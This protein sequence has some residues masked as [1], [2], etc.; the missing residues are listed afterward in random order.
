MEDE[1]AEYK[2]LSLYLL[3]RDKR[4]QI[5]TLLD[6][7]EVDIEAAYGL[8]AKTE[9]LPVEQKYNLILLGALQ[10]VNN[11]LK[12][13]PDTFYSEI[14]TDTNLYGSDKLLRNVRTDVMIGSKSI[15]SSTNNYYPEQYD[16]GKHRDDLING[17]LDYVK[18]NSKQGYGDIR[19][20]RWKGLY[21]Y[22]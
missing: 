17:L 12:I 16:Q 13:G 1:Y 8:I 18:F 20:V 9:L 10:Y 4:E 19:L 6:G 2:E 3:E 7:D 21:K 15:I 22:L 14:V 11:D 5:E